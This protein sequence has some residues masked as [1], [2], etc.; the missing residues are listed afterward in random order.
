MSDFSKR[1]ALDRMQN[2]SR[3]RWLSHVTFRRRFHLLQKLIP[4]ALVLLVVVYE[5]GPARWIHDV[6]GE[7]HH[8]VAEILMYGTV[9]PALA[10][11]LLDFVGR[12]LDERDTAELQAQVLAHARESERISREL[13]DE[14]LQTLFAASALLASLKSTLPEIP[15]ET[16]ATLRDTEQMLDQAIQK[17]RDHLQA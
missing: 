2:P 9:G 17:L 4:A 8:F 6:L 16:A 14:A 12:W 1:L 13:S 10:F 3:E 7:D 15:P 11:L 5:I